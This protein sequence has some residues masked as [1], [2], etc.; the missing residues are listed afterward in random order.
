MGSITLNTSAERDFEYPYGERW[1]LASGILSAISII[2]AIIILR[3][4][5]VVVFLLY[6]AFTSVLTLVILALKYY[7]YSRREEEMSE[8]YPVESEEVPEKG[9]TKSLV[10]LILIAMAA[11]FS[12][13][14][15]SY[16]VLTSSIDPIWWIIAISGFVPAVSIPEIILFVYARRQEK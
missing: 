15:L 9:R 6:F 12:P 10:L 14:I 5:N 3:S 8:H 1:V 16:V 13:L 11:L 2:L 7:F 4:Y